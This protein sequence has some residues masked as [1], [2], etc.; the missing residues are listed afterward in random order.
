MKDASNYILTELYTLFGSISYNS[1]AVPVYSIA[2]PAPGTADTFINMSSSTVLEGDGS[3]DSF[4]REYSVLLDIVNRRADQ[5]AAEKTVNDISNQIGGLLKLTPTSL[6]IT[7]NGDF[8]VV[9]I[10]ITDARLF[11]DRYNE[12]WHIRKVL[13]VDFLILQ[14]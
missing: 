12:K 5:V 14:K 10:N 1:V 3:K 9:K 8:D 6:G 11:T 7:G 4:V 13:T 2:Q